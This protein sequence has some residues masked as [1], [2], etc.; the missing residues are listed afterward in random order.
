MAVLYPES[1][2]SPLAKSISVRRQE[3][4]RRIE[5]DAKNSRTTN[6]ASNA[7]TIIDC[8]F[9]FD[10]V[11]LD[12]FDYFYKFTA[13]FGVNW[14][15]APWLSALGF[16]SHY[17]RFLQK[18][19]SKNNG[20]FL[21]NATI[22]VQIGAAIINPVSTGWSNSN[23]TP[24]AFP[25]VD[26]LRFWYKADEDTNP[27][28]AQYA[29]GAMI[30]NHAINSPVDF[31]VAN[32]NP[33][34][35][36]KSDVNGFKALRLSSYSGYYGGFI[37]TLDPHINASSAPKT[38]IVATSYLSTSD[39]LDMAQSDLVDVRQYRK[40]N[41]G[42]KTGTYMQ[43]Y[44]GIAG[45]SHTSFVYTRNPTNRDIF[46][47]SVA[48]GTTATI[49]HESSSSTTDAGQGI[50]AASSALFAVGCQSGKAANLHE[51]LIWDIVLNDAQIQVISDSL[52]AKWQIE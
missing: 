8:Q 4:K 30:E 36:F 27:D 29:N 5:F 2:P 51:I 37:Y 26:N 46:I 10:A 23:V 25:Y 19:E 15:D 1:L 40:M 41:Y 42:Q 33:Y 3:T 14:I 32:Q 50:S 9:V 22:E 21:L 11:Q 13:N 43:T 20:V 47:Y 45:T 44:Q 6:H 52:K 17:F 39:K 12:A 34:F 31:I 18:K 48:N 7:P 24:D 28:T 38:I 16:N 49:K 35:V